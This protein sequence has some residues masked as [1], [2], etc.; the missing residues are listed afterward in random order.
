MFSSNVALEALVLRSLEAS[1]LGK[2]FLTPGWWQE[3]KFVYLKVPVG[4][5]C[6]RTPRMDFF[7]NL[8]PL[9][10]HDIQ[11]SYFSI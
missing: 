2:S 8:L 10:T 6:V 1:L 4:L 9:Y 7:S 3:V 5:K 11:E